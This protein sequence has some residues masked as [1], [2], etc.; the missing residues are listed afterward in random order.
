MRDLYRPGTSRQESLF[1]ANVGSAV[2]TEPLSFER[3]ALVSDTEW[4]NGFMMPCPR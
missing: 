4:I 3:F 2:R 1:E